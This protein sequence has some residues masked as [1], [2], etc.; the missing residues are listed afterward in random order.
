MRIFYVIDSL[1]IGGAEMLL[2]AM[3]RTYCRAGHQID[4]AYFTPGPLAE[5]VARLG[6]PVHRVSR[7]GLKDPRAVVRLARLMHAAQ[8]DVVHTHL[9]KSDLAGQ[10]SAALVRAPARVSS[11]HNT[12]PWRK[13]P[14]L[15]TFSRAAMAPCHRVIAVS[16]EVRDYVVQWSGYPAH[17]VV[18]ID[19]GVDLERFD[20]E[21]VAPLDRAALW[22]VAPDAPAIGVIGRLEPQ[23]GHRLL[24]QAAAATAQA[25]PDVRF[26]IIGDGPLRAELEAERARLGLERVVLFAGIVRDMP[27]ALA[28]LDGVAFASLWE[29]LPV[30]LLEAMAMRR[31]VVAT[32]V[33]GI[34]GVLVDGANGLTVPP[35]DP[36]ALA[37]GVLRVVA[38]RALAARL[39]AAARETVRARYSAQA[40]HGRIMDVY[41]AALAARRAKGQ[42]A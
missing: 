33:G 3:L 38:D 12:D 1:K 35:G 39:G 18:V 28:A 24:L 32:A 11:V 2:L 20:P 31:P 19:N 10:V 14:L 34:P 26:V 41:E 25:R 7:H 13:N 40:M 16:Q 29:G 22:G 5:D 6:V 23:K 37:Q 8:P 42:R 27:G 4:V 21:T 17:K 9:T 36:E 30:A 15:S